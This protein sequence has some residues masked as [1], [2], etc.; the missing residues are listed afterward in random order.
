MPQLGVGGCT[1]RPIKL[2]AASMMMPELTRGVGPWAAIAVN[3][4][5]SDLA[6]T[7]NNGVYKTPQ[8]REFIFE[9]GGERSIVSARKGIG[10]T[11]QPEFTSEKPQARVLDDLDHAF[12]V[13]ALCKGAGYSHVTLRRPGTA[14]CAGRQARRFPP[15]LRCVRCAAKQK[16]SASADR[17]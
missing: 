5:I 10:K 1:P 17:S 7:Y 16:K 13:M 14:I 6:E 8:I 12:S 9:H 15:G 3:V 11:L 2:I 4:T